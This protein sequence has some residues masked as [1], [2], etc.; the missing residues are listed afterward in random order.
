MAFV[1]FLCNFIILFQPT[2]TLF[3]GR[4]ISIIV[5][6]QLIGL[7]PLMSRH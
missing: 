6:F 3:N 7:H 1:I 5:T 4:F 2:L